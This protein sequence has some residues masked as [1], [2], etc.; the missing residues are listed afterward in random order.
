MWP[1]QVSNPGPLTYE[2]GA[3][4]TALR[5]PAAS[6]MKPISDPRDRFF[7]PHHT[8]MKVTY[9]VTHEL[10]QLTCDVKS[11]VRTLKSEVTSLIRHH[12]KYRMTFGEG[13]LRCKI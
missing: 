9:S 2:S 5:G 11:D 10:R 13:R 8:P 1:D 4:P 12:A 7:Y 6:L 3:L